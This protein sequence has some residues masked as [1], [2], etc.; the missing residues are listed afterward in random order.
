MK[1]KIYIDYYIAEVLLGRGVPTEDPEKNGL[2]ALTLA[3]KTGRFNN[4]KL[5]LQHNAK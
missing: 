3:C 5:I 4:A 1:K 2:T